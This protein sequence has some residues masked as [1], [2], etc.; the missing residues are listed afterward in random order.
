MWFQPQ[1]GLQLLFIFSRPLLRRFFPTL[2]L[3]FIIVIIKI[4]TLYRTTFLL[5]VLDRNLYSLFAGLRQFSWYLGRGNFRLLLWRRG[6]FLLSLAEDIH[7]SIFDIENSRIVFFTKIIWNLTLSVHKIEIPNTIF[8]IIINQYLFP[9]LFKDFI[10]QS[11]LNL[12]FKT[13]FLICCGCI[14]VSVDFY[15][16]LFGL[17]SWW[18]NLHSMMLF[19][20]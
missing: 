18:F 10:L 2:D 20:W 11:L 17:L 1:G 19:K 13:R 6:F 12:L 4:N 9:P 16:V 8:N 7:Y 15:G 14:L 5:F 3:L